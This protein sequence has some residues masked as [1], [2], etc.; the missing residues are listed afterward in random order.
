M[1]GFQLEK[2]YQ[3][4]RKVINTPGLACLILTSNPQT[5][6]QKLSELHHKHQTSTTTSQIQH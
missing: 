4:L 2:L 3:P 1:M 5:G 6:E